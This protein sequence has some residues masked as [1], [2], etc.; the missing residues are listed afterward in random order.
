MNFS[1]KIAA[2]S[3]LA[4][5][6]L[7]LSACD[8]TAKKSLQAHAPAAT[9]VPLDAQALRHLPVTARQSSGY[10][11]TEPRPPL[12]SL[13]DR[14]QAQMDKGQ[15][16]FE[17]GQTQSAR[18]AWNNAS[19]ILLASGFPVDSDPRLRALFDK[20]SEAVQA[21]DAQAAPAEQASEQQE[22]Q[23]EA[24]DFEPA[25]IEE[26]AGLSLPPGDPRLARVAQQELIDVPH[27]LPL[28][29]NDSVLA[30]LSFFQT[31]RGRAT[32]E[33]GLRRASLYQ[34]MIRETL[35]EE[36]VPQDLIYLAQ[37]ESGFQPQAVS[38]A[39]AR[40]I[41]QFMAFTGEE[42]GLERTSWTDD[43][44][45]PVKS[46]R[47]AARHFRDLYRI[48]GDWYLVMAAYNSGPLNVARGV[49]RTGYA[50][51]WEL[52]KRDALPAETRNYVPII[53]AM[54]LVAKDPARYGVQVAPDKP[55]QTDVAKPGHSVSLQL[56]ADAT[57]SS[58]ETLRMLNPSLLRAVTPDDSGFE[59]HV[60]FGSGARLDQALQMIPSDKWTTWRMYRLEGSES[61]AAIAAKYH[62]T[63]ASLASVNRLQADD[64]PASG[65][66][67]I[68][69]S[70]PRPT[71][72]VIHYRVRRGDTLDDIASRF[73][74]TASD[75]R[76]WNHLRGSHAPVGAQLK[77]ITASPG[78]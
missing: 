65:T 74:V 22:N 4:L 54:A 77:I 33:N 53:I 8:Q 39:G 32:I 21:I 13:I 55:L 27:D 34:D 11:T 30:Y 31:R 1:G 18:A 56:A 75:L 76:K 29:V 48:F 23:E 35:K 63:V 25:P 51:F 20:L 43:R 44:N 16:L 3:V 2:W 78:T 12:D 14:V 24:E 37:A 58:V 47:A 60:P 50:D 46:T 62:V 5:A 28:T 15:K 40:G 41:W 10:L 68:I 17:A 64:P 67:I 52:Q 6:L 66:L 57:G 36:G 7:S 26:I 72:R 19:N 61:L 9:P 73:G 42:Y 71:S 70:A 45:D 38:R 49:E 59:L 69:P